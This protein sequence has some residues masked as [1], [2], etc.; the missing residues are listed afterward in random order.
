MIHT[1]LERNAV[2]SSSLIVK[3][4]A[5]VQVLPALVNTTAIDMGHNNQF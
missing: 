3:G 2:E 5:A 4:S 1:L